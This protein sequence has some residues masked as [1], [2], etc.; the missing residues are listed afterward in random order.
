MDQHF[1]RALLQT[2]R[3]RCSWIPECHLVGDIQYIFDE[4]E[5]LY[6]KYLIPRMHHY[7]EVH[8]LLTPAI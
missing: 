4:L 2:T 7:R 6:L 3:L 5:F 8:S 1:T